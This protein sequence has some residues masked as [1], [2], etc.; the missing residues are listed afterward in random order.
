MENRKSQQKC[1][2][3]W[4]ERETIDTMDEWKGAKWT[5]MERERLIS[6]RD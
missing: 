2:M 5:E 1:D 6:Q 4:R 3:R